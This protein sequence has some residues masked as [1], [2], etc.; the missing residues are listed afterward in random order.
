M[1]NKFFV[2]HFPYLPQDEIHGFEHAAFDKMVGVRP[3]ESTF[4]IAIGKMR[5]LL[6][7]GEM[8]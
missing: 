2:T 4:A 8:S 6:I 7:D 5:S 1:Q 3:G